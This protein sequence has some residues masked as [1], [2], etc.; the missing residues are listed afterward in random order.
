MADPSKVL[1]TVTRFVSRTARRDR[2]GTQ[3][4]RGLAGFRGPV[5]EGLQQLRLRGE[6]WE[7]REERVK[8][9]D[10]PWGQTGREEESR[11]WQR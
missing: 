4:G 10:G 5:L 9:G 7:L 11:W 2:V 6:R 3:K 8:E 1:G